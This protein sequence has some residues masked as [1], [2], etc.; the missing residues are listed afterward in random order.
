MAQK[1]AA[2]IN[3]ARRGKM[4][5]EEIKLNAEQSFAARQLWAASA[6]KLRE[7]SR[8]ALEN[9]SKD[10]QF[11]LR[12]QMVMHYAIQKKIIAARTETACA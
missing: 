2:N 12:K 7:L 11:M 9:P 4:T 5:F 3:K 8:M 6:A 1:D 10:N